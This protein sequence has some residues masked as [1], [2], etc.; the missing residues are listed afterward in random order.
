MSLEKMDNISTENVIDIT[1]SHRATIRCH[2]HKTATHVTWRQ[3]FNSHYL[4]ANL[5]E[6]EWM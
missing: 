4:T 5:L 1:W 3:I 2:H 6:R